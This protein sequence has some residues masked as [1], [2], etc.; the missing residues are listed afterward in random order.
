MTKYDVLCLYK[1]K[2]IAMDI[3][4]H[5]VDLAS[6]CGYVTVNQYLEM[7]GI[8]EY[9]EGGHEWGWYAK[10]IM[11]TVGV[12]TRCG[13]I[14]DLGDPYLV[15]EKPKNGRYSWS[16]TEESCDIA[17]CTYVYESYEEVQTMLRAIYAIANT[18][19]YVTLYDFLILNRV[20]KEY[21]INTEGQKKIG[22]SCQM[23]SNAKIKEVFCGYLLNLGTPVDISTLK[24]MPNDQTEKN[25]YPYKSGKYP[26]GYDS[27]TIPAILIDHA[28][29]SIQNYIK[30]GNLNNLK[31]ARDI[32]ITAIIELEDEESEEK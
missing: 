10:T 32:L 14:L 21:P 20:N 25:A 26:F 11:D 31:A 2:D 1:T 6:T 9:M 16:Y 23:V 15:V 8:D 24:N 12:K 19:G 3:L 22:W 28:E 7:S 17:D 4:K 30:Y 13:W 29:D 5:M 18:C 27:N